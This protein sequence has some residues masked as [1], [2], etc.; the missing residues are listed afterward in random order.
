MQ[1]NLEQIKEIVDQYPDY[2][3]VVNDKIFA[4]VGKEGS[5]YG[6][7]CGSLEWRQISTNEENNYDVDIRKIPMWG[8]G[9][10]YLGE[11]LSASVHCS[12]GWRD[13][14]LDLEPTDGWE[15]RWGDGIILPRP[16]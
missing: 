13:L 7:Q 11:R 9:D 5:T 1:M 2:F 14:S 12:L 8:R 16:S 4:L 6:G 15:H 3:H 10:I